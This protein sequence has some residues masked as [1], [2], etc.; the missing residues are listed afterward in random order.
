MPRSW[1]LIPLLSVCLAAESNKLTFDQRVEI[2]RGLMAEYATVKAPLPR[3]KKPLEYESNGRYD[4]KHWDEMGK[5][6]GPAARVGDLVQITKVT[7]ED[8]KI[9]FEINGGNRS[10]RKWYQ[11]VEVGMG[12]STTPIHSGQNTNAPAGTYISLLFGKP[13]PPMQAAEI[14][15]LLTPILDFEKRS[16]SEQA[17][18]SM[19]PEIKEAVKENRAIEGMDRS[20]V[21]LAL[22]KPRM[23]TRE[24]KDG[25]DLE[26][27][28]YGNPPGKMVFVTFD[29]TKV[30]KVKETYAGLG[31]QTAPPLPAR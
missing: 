6:L 1:F 19:P 20:Q 21:I 26:D 30:V 24:T 12:N 27:W 14:K 23:K 13:V 2:V 22:G 18:E 31:G 3:T 7:I 25:A 16:A 11:N 15:K 4:K 8:E 28:I 5:E 17:V 10:K 9:L 29:G